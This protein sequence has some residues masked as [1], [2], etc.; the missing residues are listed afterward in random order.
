MSKERPAQHVTWA[1]TCRDIVVA[2]INKG[3][4]PLVILGAVLLLLIWRMPEPQVG[5]LVNRLLDGLETGWLVGYLLWLTT[6][7]VWFVHA[8]HQQ[9]VMALEIARLSDERSKLQETLGGGVQ[10]SHGR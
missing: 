10:S 1:Q 7:G 8:R 4:L 5:D 2:S 9:R 3:Q 6:V